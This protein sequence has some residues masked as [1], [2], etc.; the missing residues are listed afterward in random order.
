MWIV[1]GVNAG[2]PWVI[3]RRSEKQCRIGFQP[4]SGSTGRSLPGTRS[5]SLI[6]KV[7]AIII[8]QRSDS[9]WFE[10]VPW[11]GETGW[12]PILHCARA[13]LRWG[14]GHVP[15]MP[16]SRHGLSFWTSS[17]IVF[18]PGLARRAAPFQGGYGVMERFPGLKTR[19]SKASRLTSPAGAN[20]DG[21]LTPEQIKHLNPTV[22][23]AI[24][25]GPLVI[26]AFR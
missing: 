1:S 24:V 19:A 2:Q 14:R 23:T 15:L 9:R 5:S 10:F 7:S 21:L 26:Y 13:S 16:L 11:F 8:G 20:R 25:P 17:Y 6:D 18:Q 22:G 12:K 4:V 3:A